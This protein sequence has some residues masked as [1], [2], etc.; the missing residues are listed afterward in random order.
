MHER[1]VFTHFMAS[2]KVVE[3]GNK[4]NMGLGFF[5]IESTRNHCHF[6]VRT[7]CTCRLL[8]KVRLMSLEKLRKCGLEG[9]SWFLLDLLHEPNTCVLT[10]E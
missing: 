7:T 10:S 9:M 2:M 4:I 6:G 5:S 3:T 1:A 8:Y